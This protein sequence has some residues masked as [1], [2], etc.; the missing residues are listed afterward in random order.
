MQLDQLE[1]QRQ[2]DITSAQG[3]SQ[4]AMYKYQGKQA[5]S[6]YKWIAA[7]IQGGVSSVGS[8]LA[9]KNASSKPK[10]GAN[11]NQTTKV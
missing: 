1:L 8:G 2:Q 10:G 6:P 3:A 4:S 9:V 11:G 5:A 7:G